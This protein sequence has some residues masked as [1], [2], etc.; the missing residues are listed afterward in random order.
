MRLRDLGVIEDALLEL[1]PGLT[2]VTGETGAGKTMLLAGLSLLRGRRAEPRLV[3]TG[4]SRALVE[5]RLRVAA[6][7]PVLARAYEAGAE[8]DEDGS[9]VLARSVSREG[10]SRAVLGGAAV[11]AAVLAEVGDA[12]VSVCGQRDGLRLL[13]PEHQREALDRAAGVSGLAD[14]HAARWEQLQE[15]RAVLRDRSAWSAARAAATER[16]EGALSEVGAAAPQPG[17]AAALDALLTR[18]GDADALRTAAGEAQLLLSGDVDAAHEA[19]DARSLVADAAR[20][21]GLAAGSDLALAGLRDRVTEVGELLADVAADL[22][23]YAQ[24][25]EADPQA[26]AVAQER[27]AVLRGLARRLRSGPAPFALVPDGAGRAPGDVAVLASG[28]LPHDDAD[29]L[30]AWSARASE[31]VARLRGHDGDAEGLRRREAGLLDAL[32]SSAGRLARARRTTAS[33]LQDEVAGR[34]AEL[35]MPRA[36]VQVDVTSRPAGSGDEAALVVDGRRWRAGPAGVDEVELRLAPDPGSPPRPLAQGASG[37]ELSRVVLALEVVLGDAERVPVLVL[38]EVD[39]GIGGRTAVA[40]GRL[41]ARAARSRQVLVV[42]HLA[43]VAAFADT[44]LRVEKSDDGRVTRS[45]VVALDEAGRCEELTR[46]L[47]G[48]EGSRSGREH[49]EELRGVAR[50]ACLD[51]PRPG[52][53]AGRGRA[54]ALS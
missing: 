17:E 24:G 23:S 20:C 42:T 5:G 49:A 29:A 46:M 36:V 33:R 10:R 53:P 28:D 19:R 27:R 12:L 30:L 38:D 6:D 13:R 50:R 39:S 22:A 9:L 45:G 47:S 35:G 31:R 8:V 26:L 41:L 1:G 11:P 4:A 25:V 32:A 51:G 21:L 52:A 43:Q 54:R 48:L 40:V 7:D 15:V 2:V 34:L 44:H 37:G 3:R 18:L 14:E 16:L